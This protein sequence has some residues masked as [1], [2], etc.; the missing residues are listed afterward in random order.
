MRDVQD[1]T[2]DPAPTA[3]MTAATPEP[4]LRV[5]GLVK[6]FG[7]TTVL[8]GVDLRVDD[9]EIVGLIGVSGS[10]KS[11]LLRCLNY[12]EMPDAGAVYLRGERLGV[13]ETRSGAERP[14]PPSVLAR[15]RCRMTMV[16][17]RFHLWPHRTALQ[18]VTD[19]PIT[20]LRRDRA[21]ALDRG[22]ALLERFG[23]GD[24]VDAYP[25]KLSGGQQQRV[26]IARA[27]AMEPELILLDEPTSALDPE[28]VQEV[29]STLRTLKDDGMA[30]I[31][32][33]HELAF[34]RDVCTRILFLDRGRIAAQGAADRLLG[35]DAPEAVRR[36]MGL[37]RHGPQPL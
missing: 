2:T 30:M 14:V 36:Y 26:G 23:L 37:L 17:Q 6:R 35:D 21:S 19:G 27:L 34:A 1:G 28:L 22:R 24:K 4:L 8:D 20:V 13:R 31:I 5:A 16:F 10:G 32:V 9:R 11:T 29:L 25:N 33:T 15:Q 7:A 3:L 18:N 12:L